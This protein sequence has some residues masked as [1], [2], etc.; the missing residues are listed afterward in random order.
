MHKFKVIYVRIKKLN[1]ITGNNKIILLIAFM[2][3]IRYS[4]TI[5]DDLIMKAILL[6]MLLVQST[7]IK[8][9]T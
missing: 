6:E 9:R 8:M 5:N 1:K 4:C 3:I 7:Q 2:E